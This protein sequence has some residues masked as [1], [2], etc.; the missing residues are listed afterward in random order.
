MHLVQF[1]AR[2]IRQPGQR[3]FFGRDDVILFFFAERYMLNPI[4]RPIRSIF[5]KKRFATDAVGI[6][7]QR[8]RTP[9]DVGQNSGRNFKIIL[10]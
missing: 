9:F 2:Q 7:H 5:L 3:R 1:D 8:Q 6:T 10:D 4:V